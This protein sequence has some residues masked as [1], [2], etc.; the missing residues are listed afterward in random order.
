MPRV[1]PLLLNVPEV[2]TAP[3]DFI[4]PKQPELIY[5]MDL[6]QLEGILFVNAMSKAQE[7]ITRYITGDGPINELGEVDVNAKGYIPPKDL[8][9]IN[10]EPL[11]VSE[12]AFRIAAGIAAAQVCED[13]AD[14]YSVLDIIFLMARSSAIVEQLS[15]AYSEIQSGAAIDPNPSPES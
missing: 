1:D 2:S 5:H 12:G 14:R 13:T 6:R 11:T 3:F 7:Y 10:G 15:I 4:D 9:P 8:P